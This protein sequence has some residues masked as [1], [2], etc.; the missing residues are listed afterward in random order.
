MAEM[1]HRRYLR[2]IL[3]GAEGVR[4]VGVLQRQRARFDG[5]RPVL[6]RAAAF[7]AGNAELADLA[8]IDVFAHDVVHVNSAAIL[9]DDVD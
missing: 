2:G 4:E 5:H 8:G 7:D 6:V 9:R 1:G 3:G